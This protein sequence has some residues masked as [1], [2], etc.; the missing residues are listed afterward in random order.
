MTLRRVHR[1]TPG[2]DSRIIC[3][4]IEATAANGLLMAAAFVQYLGCDL[5]TQIA[6][7]PGRFCGHKHRFT[8]ARDKSAAGKRKR[9]HAERVLNAVN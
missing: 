2:Q 9:T 7:N 6:A 3:K 4:S 5:R 8:A 1:K